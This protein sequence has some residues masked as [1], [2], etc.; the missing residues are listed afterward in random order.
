MAE[1]S[2]LIVYADESGNHGMEKIDAEF[3]VFALVFCLFDKSVYN[4]I[5]E[6]AVRQLKFKYFGHDAA[7]FHEREVRK[8]LPPFDFLRGNSAL[9]AAFYADLDALIAAM[10]MR[11]I[12]SV[13]DKDRHRKRYTD[14]WNPYEIAM[15]FCLETL[16]DRL[17]ADGQAGRLVH[18]LFESRG[19]AEDASLELE[20]R[21]ITQNHS[22]WGSRR[23]DFSLCQ[24]EPVFVP[25][26]ANH[27]GHQISDLVARPLALR[28]LRPAQANRAA[29]IAWDK[30]S[31][32]KLFP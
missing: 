16:C 23:V 7:I 11:V 28:A 17:V 32:W 19:K 18:V 1:F 27:A 3:P 9:R 2:D 30:V 20:F 5:V 8:Q 21:R 6:P 4:S 15:H 26:A 24:F 25:K 31:D 14:P 22:H 13:I 12:A 10:P 29:A